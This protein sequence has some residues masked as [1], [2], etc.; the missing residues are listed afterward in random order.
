MQ[1]RHCCFHPCPPPVFSPVPPEDSLA[2]RGQQWG[3]GCR[4]SPWK[5]WLP[6][7]NSK[8]PQTHK[9]IPNTFGIRSCTFSLTMIRDN[10]LVY[11]LALWVS[12]TFAVSIFYCS[13]TR[14]TTSAWSECSTS[15]GNGFR[16]RQRICKQVK[17]NSTAVT[18]PLG[19][20]GHKHPLE[21]RSC[22]G[23]SCTEWVIHPWGQVINFMSD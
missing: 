9:N 5:A 20:C 17:A 12:I 16:Q 2:R 8:E 15:C 13:I 7:C 21:R 6:I 18:L 3:V 1:R 11:P 4:I 19:T 14:W 22:T 10:G 23:H